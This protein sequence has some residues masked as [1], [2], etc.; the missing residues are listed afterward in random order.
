MKC[1]FTLITHQTSVKLLAVTRV[2]YIPEKSRDKAHARSA[3]LSYKLNFCYLHG[4][5]GFINYFLGTR[6][7]FYQYVFP[8]F[9]KYVNSNPWLREKLLNLA[10]ISDAATEN[11][12]PCKATSETGIC[13]PSGPHACTSAVNS[14]RILRT[15]P[16]KHMHSQHWHTDRYTHTPYK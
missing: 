7:Q 1:I 6:Q 8:Q 10:C 12:F 11:E 2:A 15:Y 14:R 16:R 13:I 4:E 3:L 5:N 9:Q